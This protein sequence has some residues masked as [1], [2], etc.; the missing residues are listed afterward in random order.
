MSRL[1]QHTEKNQKLYFQ[2]D[3]RGKVT[4]TRDDPEK[5][6]YDNQSLF[7]AYFRE[8]RYKFY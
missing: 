5:G 7:N 8:S 4:L 1:L 3:Q 2:Y 6:A